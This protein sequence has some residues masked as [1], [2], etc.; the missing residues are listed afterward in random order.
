MFTKKYAIDLFPLK[1]DGK[2]GNDGLQFSS[3]KTCGGP[4]FQTLSA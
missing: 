2:L 1:S 4:T 3:E